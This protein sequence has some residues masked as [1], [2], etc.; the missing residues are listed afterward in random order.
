MA[1]L[2]SGEHAQAAVLPHSLRKRSCDDQHI[3]WR[4]E[5]KEHVQGV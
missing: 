2:M 4:F 5:F 3:D 1:G